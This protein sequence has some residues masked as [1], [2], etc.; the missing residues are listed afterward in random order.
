M[1]RRERRKLESRGQRDEF[2]PNKHWKLTYDFRIPPHLV[3]GP[4][5]GRVA[6]TLEARDES[7][8]LRGFLVAL[9][10]AAGFSQ[11]NRA[12]IGTLAETLNPFSK[13]MRGQL[14]YALIEGQGLMFDEDEIEVCAECGSE[15]EQTLH[16]DP[17][18][19]ACPTEEPCVKQPDGSHHDDCPPVMLDTTKH[20]A[21]CPYQ[22]PGSVPVYTETTAINILM[23]RKYEHINAPAAEDAA[24]EVNTERK[25]AEV[26]EALEEG[27]TIPDDE[28]ELYQEG[29]A[30]AVAGEVAH[31][32]S[33]SDAA[34]A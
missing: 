18:Y 6:G 24:Q 23:P 16:P 29:E 20:G 10:N 21:K 8:L 3:R 31:G 13:S 34:G 5:P 4:H 9:F 32:E 30:L 19:A 7:D 15:R 33:E 2:D 14:A 27:A 26:A 17:D 1:N 22:E 11:D 28:G 25:V 12:V